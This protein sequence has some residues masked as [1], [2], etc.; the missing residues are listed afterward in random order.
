MKDEVQRLQERQL[1]GSILWLLHD[2]Y[3]SG[4][5]VTM[6]S[7][8]KVTRR[9]E[10]DPVLQAA[11]TFLIECGYAAKVSYP[12]DQRDENPAVDYR[13]TATGRRVINGD[14]KDDSI[15]L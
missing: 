12:L 6:K 5:N 1:N 14:L 11:L 7:I 9:N 3:G 13:L 2:F 15:D 8:C 4:T 10:T